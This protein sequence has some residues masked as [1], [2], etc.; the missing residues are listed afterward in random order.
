[1]ARNVI[2]TISLTVEIK[3]VMLCDVFCHHSLKCAIDHNHV[4]TVSLCGLSK[5]YV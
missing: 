4:H 3:L 5:L 2:K 1:M